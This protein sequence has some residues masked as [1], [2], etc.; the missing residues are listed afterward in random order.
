MTREGAQV[1]GQPIVAQSQGTPAQGGPVQGAPVQGTP[2]QGTP[3]QGTPVQATPAQ[4][5]PDASSRLG[6]MG[7]GASSALLAMTLSL[8]SQ[9]PA[10]AHDWYPMECCHERDCAPVESV[11]TLAPASTNALATLVVT[12]KYGTA[13]VPADFPRRESKDNRMHACMR[14]GATGRIHLLCFFVPPPS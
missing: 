11:E 4:G 5:T 13:V 2:V 6:S 12:T 10:I 1:F 3:V 14:Q 9:S 7:R 8:A